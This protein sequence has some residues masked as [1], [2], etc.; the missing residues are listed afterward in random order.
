MAKRKYYFDLSVQI[1]TEE[2]DPSSGYFYSVIQTHSERVGAKHDLLAFGEVDTL[3]DAV[4]EIRS[5]V[6]LTL[7]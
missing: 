6:D 7:E 2:D 5:A 3:D 4:D 1:W